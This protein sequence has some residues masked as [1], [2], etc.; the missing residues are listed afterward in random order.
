MLINYLFLILPSLST[1]SDLGTATAILAQA[2]EACQPTPRHSGRHHYDKH[3]GDGEV[4]KIETQRSMGA[5]ERGGAED[6]TGVAGVR[7][8]SG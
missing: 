2:A 4:G 6:T 5:R 1:F 7:E 3:I 8:G